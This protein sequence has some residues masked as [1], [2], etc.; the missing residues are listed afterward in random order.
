MTTMLRP[1][2]KGSIRLHQWK[3]LSKTFRRI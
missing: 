3:L 1:K 2:F